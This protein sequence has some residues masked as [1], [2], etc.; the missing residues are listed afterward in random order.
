MC[1]MPCFYKT[2]RRVPINYAIL[3]VFTLAHSWLIAYICISYQQSVVIAAAICTMGMFIALTAYACITKTDMTYMG[4]LLST[5]SMMVLLILIL[6]MFF[7]TKLLYIIMLGVLIAL[8][9]MWIIH[10][11]Q[12]IIGGKHRAAEL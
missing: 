12:L 9:S 11:T 4:G 6:M 10:D 2:L 1:Y 3:A 8:L 5:A 7:M